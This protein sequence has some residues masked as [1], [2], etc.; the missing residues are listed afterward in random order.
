MKH[1]YT[2]LCLFL[3]SGAACASSIYGTWEFIVDQEAIN[4]GRLQPMET[5]VYFFVEDHPSSQ[6]HGK[7]LSISADGIKLPDGTACQFLSSKTVD[8]LAYLYGDYRGT[9][10]REGSGIVF[11]NQYARIIKTNCRQKSASSTLEE[12]LHLD[13]LWIANEGNLIFMTWVDDVEWGNAH[14][15]MERVE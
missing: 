12:Q 3:L 13:E 5:P 14:I 6:L 11:N 9:I 4:G 10:C 1:I 2:F 15:E 7:Q 8:V